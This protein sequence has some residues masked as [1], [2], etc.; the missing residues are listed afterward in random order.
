VF[1]YSRIMNDNSLPVAEQRRRMTQ[2]EKR[3]IV[4]VAWQFKLLPWAPSQLADWAD[5]QG[6]QS[7]G[8][9]RLLRR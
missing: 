7:R 2:I 1:E 6:T 8:R 5:P 9:L 4:S 3:T